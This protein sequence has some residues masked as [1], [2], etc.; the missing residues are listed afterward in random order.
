MT[1]LT[2]SYITTSLKQS[3][4]EDIWVNQVIRTFYVWKLVPSAV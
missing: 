3:I 2:A 4:E 1:I